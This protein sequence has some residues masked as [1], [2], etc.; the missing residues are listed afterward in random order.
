MTLTFTTELGESAG[1]WVVKG[2]VDQA[3]EVEEAETGWGQEASGRDQDPDRAYN[4]APCL[5][6]DN[7][8]SSW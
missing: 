2:A 5:S 8:P 3:M 1:E 4:I 7:Q 6:F